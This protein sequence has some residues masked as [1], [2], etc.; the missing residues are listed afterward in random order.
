MDY[1]EA[2]RIREEIVDG[3]RPEWKKV[4]RNEIPDA[5]GAREYW[6]ARN[7]SSEVMRHLADEQDVPYFRLARTRGHSMHM[8]DS[9]IE[10]Q[11]HVMERARQHYLNAVDELDAATH[12]HEE[13]ER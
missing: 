5:P 6:R 11:A 1:E 9:S 4:K 8:P 7:E 13:M 12:D 10:A 3:I 2:C